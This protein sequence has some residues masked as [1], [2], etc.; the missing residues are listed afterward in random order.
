MAN[1]HKLTPDVKPS[2]VRNAHLTPKDLDLLVESDST[3]V[4]GR[5]FLHHLSICPPCRAVGGFLLHA[6]EAGEID[7]ELDGFSIQLSRSRFHAPALWKKLEARRDHKARVDVVKKT[8]VSGAGDSPSSC[9]NAA[10]VW[11]LMSLLR[12]LL[13][14]SLPSKLASGSTGTILSSFF[15]ALSGRT[16]GTLGEN[17]ATFRVRC[18]PF[19]GRKSFG[20]QPSRI[21]GTFSNMKDATQPSCQAKNES[22]NSLRTN[23]PDTP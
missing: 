3:M 14:P 5:I 22:S 20:I 19:T 21:T 23:L 10:W 13:L 2:R 8:G 6:L 16:W 18:K 4:L 1:S 15:A 11:R 9:A 7:E 17:R 12:P